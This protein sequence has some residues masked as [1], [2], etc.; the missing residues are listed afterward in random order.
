MQPKLITP[1]LV[2]QTWLVFIPAFYSFFYGGVYGTYLTNHFSTRARALSSLIVRTL[3][4][5][6][7]V[8]CN[9]SADTS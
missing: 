6:C 7:L 1:T 2:L 3:Q 8:P 5:A 4:Q 9:V